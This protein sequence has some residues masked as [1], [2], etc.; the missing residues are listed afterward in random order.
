MHREPCAPTWD[1]KRNHSSPGFHGLLSN[2]PLLF[3]RNF[4]LFWE[5]LGLDAISNSNSV[6]PDWPTFV[7]SF[8][9]VVDLRSSALTMLVPIVTIAL[10]WPNLELGLADNQWQC[11]ESDANFQNIASVSWGE[12]W[13]AVCNTPVGKWGASLFSF[14]FFLKWFHFYL[15][16]EYK[17]AVSLKVVTGFWKG[18][19]A[20]TYLS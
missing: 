16:S 6:C 11:N 17:K 18:K 15:R 8:K 19:D 13:K 2:H 7:F 20:S 14:F 10:E 3:P 9:Q 12:I 1:S 5:I 4:L